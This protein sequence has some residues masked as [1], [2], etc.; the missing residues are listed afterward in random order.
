MAKTNGKVINIKDAPKG[1]IEDH[2]Y[3]YIG[4]ST[5]KRSLYSGYYGN[6]F[7]LEKEE[8]RGSTLEKF[9]KWARERLEKEKFYRLMVRR[10][11]GKTLVCYCAPSPCHGDILLKLAKE[12]HDKEN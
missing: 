8:A 11:Y 1:W 7:K 2:S 3:V 4:R 9:E 5:G 6:P 12:L 10:L